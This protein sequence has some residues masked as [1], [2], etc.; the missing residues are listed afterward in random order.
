L[1]VPAAPGASQL[2]LFKNQPGRIRWLASSWLAL[3]SG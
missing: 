3:M 2:I 1:L